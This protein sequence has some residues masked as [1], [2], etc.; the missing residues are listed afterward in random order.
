MAW[1]MATEASSRQMQGNEHKSKSQEKHGKQTLLHDKRPT[2]ETSRDS[3]SRK[4][5][6]CNNRP[7]FQLWRLNN[8]SNPKKLWSPGLGFICVY[9]QS[10]G[11]ATYLEYAQAVWNPYKQG[12][13]DQLENVQKRATKQV[14]SLKDLSYE[15]RL[16]KTKYP[17]DGHIYVCPYRSRHIDFALSIRLSVCLSTCHAVSGPYLCT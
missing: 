3:W 1:K 10:P 15:D 17:N 2:E 8:G 4:R 6:W 16:K 14:M 12:Q 9:V 5:L 7:A 11:T 13:K